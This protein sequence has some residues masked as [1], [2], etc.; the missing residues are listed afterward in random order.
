[1]IIPNNK[2]ST[3]KRIVWD[4]P[5]PRGATIELSRY[6]MKHDMCIST[7]FMIQLQPHWNSFTLDSNVVAELLDDC[8]AVQVL[9]NGDLGEIRFE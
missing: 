5:A 2:F 8:D 3:Y 4:K 7:C 9:V 1:M 6:S